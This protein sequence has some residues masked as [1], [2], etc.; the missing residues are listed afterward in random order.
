MTTDC[1]KVNCGQ[2][3]NILSSVGH[4]HTTIWEGIVAVF[5]LDRAQLYVA[6]VSYHFSELY[7]SLFPVL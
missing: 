1:I 7:C 2:T 3:E 6:T 4:S 5:G